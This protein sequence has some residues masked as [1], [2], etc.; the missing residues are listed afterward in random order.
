MESNTLINNNS[1]N[2][3]NKHNN[4]NCSP[5]VRGVSRKTEEEMPRKERPT[6]KDIDQIRT[7]HFPV[8]WVDWL[9][10]PKGEAD[11]KSSI[12][13]FSARHLPDSYLNQVRV[14]LNVGQYSQMTEKYRKTP[15]M[16]KDQKCRINYPFD[17]F[18]AF[19]F[20]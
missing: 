8:S 12:D 18:R 3:N 10:R 19:G 16:C 13:H 9:K 17:K 7:G 2:N 4:T 1:N 14:V 6:K 15:R 11:W 20:R 5:S